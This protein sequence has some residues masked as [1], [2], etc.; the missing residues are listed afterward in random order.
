MNKIELEPLPYGFKDLS[1]YIS[2]KAIEYNYIRYHK[3]YVDTLITYLC[4]QDTQ[5]VDLISIIGS[6]SL[7]NRLPYVQNILFNNIQE[8]IIQNKNIFPHIFEA[9]KYCS[10]G[11]ITNKLYE[12]GGYYR[13][14]M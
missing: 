13:R 3:L 4:N 12:V 9:C 8:S 14:N 2:E 10:L 5:Y 11:S 1:P 7:N 6:K